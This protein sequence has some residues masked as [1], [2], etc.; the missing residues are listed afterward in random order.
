MERP[1]QLLQHRQTT[2][3]QSEVLVARWAEEELVVVGQATEGDKDSKLQSRGSVF[4][5]GQLAVWALD[6]TS[7]QKS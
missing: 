1:W 6:N 7:A 3:V 2:N 5:E 4:A